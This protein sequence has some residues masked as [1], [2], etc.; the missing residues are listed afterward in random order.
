MKPRNPLPLYL[1]AACLTGL[2]LG[3]F[4]FSTS[5]EKVELSLFNGRLSKMQTVINIIDYKYVDDIDI[6]SLNELTIPFLLAQLDPHS[7]YIP[8]QELNEVDK[9]VKGGFYGVGIENYPFNDTSFVISLTPNGPSSHLDIRPGDKIVEVDGDDVTGK[10][11]KKIT[12]AHLRGDQGT[13]VKVGLKRHGVDS[14]IMVEITRELV[15]VKS[16]TA[17]YM[18][19][20]TTA[21]IKMESFSDN[22]HF[23]FVGRT[24]ILRQLGAQN[25]IID[26]RGNLGGRVEQAKRIASEILRFG[27]T[28]VSTVGR[29]NVTDDIFIDTTRIGICAGMRIAC[30]VDNRTASAAEILAAAIQDNDRGVIIGRRTF[31]KG[32]VQTPIQMP[33]GSQV[34]LTTLR[35][36]TPSGRSLQKDYNTYNSDLNDRYNNGEYDSATAFKPKDTT[37]YFTKHHRKVYSKSGVMPDVFVPITRDAP[38]P[39]A[40]AMDKHLTTIHYAIV[41]YNALGINDRKVYLDTLFADEKATFADLLTF[42][43][44]NGVNI[45]PRKDKKELAECHD[46]IMAWLKSDAYHITGDD[47]ISKKYLN[48]NDSAINVALSILNDPA[49]LDRILNINPQ[50]EK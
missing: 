45:D 24:A 14:L 41:R 16:A 49:Q 21:Y 36:Y 10:D 42:A 27:D 13:K 4:C 1:F 30:I 29:N 25:L 5:K 8:A 18:A 34:R 39:I 28:I 48:Y 9:S 17:S 31:G 32:L 3:K 2:L 33:D 35:Y 46:K 40:S 6:D 50:S 23:E 43:R 7:A 26:L 19:D 47:D 12:S 15:P 20:S 11:A 37:A 44:R 38:S 22:S